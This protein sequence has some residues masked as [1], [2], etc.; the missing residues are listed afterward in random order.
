MGGGPVVNVPGDFL[1]ETPVLQEQEV[2]VENRRFLLTDTSGKILDE[3]Q[4]FL[5]HVDGIKCRSGSLNRTHRVI[6]GCFRLCGR[7]RE[8]LSF[9]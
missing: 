3:R 8:S 2:G 1:D 9:L 4:D 5:N 7:N 6:G